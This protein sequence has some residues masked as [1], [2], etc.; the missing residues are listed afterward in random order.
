MVAIAAAFVFAGFLAYWQAFRTDLADEPTNPRV[1]EAFTDPGR[2]RILDRNGRLLVDS[3]ADGRAF[4]TT[5]PWPMSSGTSMP[6]LARRGPS[7]PSTASSV[8]PK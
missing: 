6:A 7:S 8:A 2:G 4:T 3:A 5:W 1:L